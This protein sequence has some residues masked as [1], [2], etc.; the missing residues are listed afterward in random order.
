MTVRAVRSVS[1]GP[2]TRTQATAYYEQLDQRLKSQTQQGVPRSEAA[3]GAEQ[4]R[5]GSWG[6]GVGQLDANGTASSYQSGIGRPRF[7]YDQEDQ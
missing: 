5:L 7:Q 3:W 2:A 6:S 1:D 4:Q